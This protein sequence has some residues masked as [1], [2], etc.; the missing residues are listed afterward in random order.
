MKYSLILFKALPF[1]DIITFAFWN[2]R[3]KSEEETPWK[4]ILDLTFV[5]IL[6]FSRICMIKFPRDPCSLFYHHFF[7]PFPLLLSLQLHILHLSR[8][9]CYTNGWEQISSVFITISPMTNTW[10]L[11]NLENWFNFIFW[12]T[13]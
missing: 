3:K 10:C 8:W 4:K 2:W 11:P 12:K 6:S 9:L 1:Q 5:F 7:P 13:K